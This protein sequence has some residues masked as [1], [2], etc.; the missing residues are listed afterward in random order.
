MN[1]LI[2][3]HGPIHLEPQ[4]VE[5]YFS[6]LTTTIVGQQVSAKAAATI[7]KRVETMAGEMSSS[8]VNTLS[9]EQMRSCGLS[10][11][12]VRYIKNLAEQFQK[13]NIPVND[14]MTMSEKEVWD[15]LIKEPGIGAWTIEMFMIE[16]LAKEDVWSVGDM[17]LRKAVRISFGEEVDIDKTAEAWQ[18]YRSVASLY[19]WKIIDG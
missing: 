14:F 7:S 10:Q 12:K 1:T 16:A 15:I 4:P 8:A 11:S 18:P 19:L 17:A 13:Q 2:E 5:N 6:V 3:T 9:V